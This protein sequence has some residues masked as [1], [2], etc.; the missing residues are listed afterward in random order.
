VLIGHSQ[1]SGVLETVIAQKIDNRPSIRKR[2][3][4]AILMGGNVLVKGNSGIG[5]NFKH[6]PPAAATTSWGA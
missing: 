1:G 5:G 3:L 2:L 4:S 6:I